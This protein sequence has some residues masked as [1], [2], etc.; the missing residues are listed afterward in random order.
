MTA[1]YEAR[2][3]GVHSAQPSARAK[4]LCP[5]LIF[6]PP[7]FAA[8]RAAAETIRAVFREYTGLVEPLSLD[9][10]FLDVTKPLKGPP[11][12]T[13][14]AKEIKARIL[15]QTGL[16]ASAGI[17]H[18]KFLAKVASAMNKPDGLTIVTPEEAEAF[19]AKLPIEKFF[20]VGPATTRRFKALGVM[21]GADLKEMPR[22]RLVRLFGKSGHW[23]YRIAR[24]E[25]RRPVSPDRERKTLSA[26]RTFRED[27][28]SIEEM[29]S[30]II[31]IVGE[32]TRRMKKGG[33]EGRTVTVKIKY[34]DFAI[35]TR[36]R[37]LPAAIS[38]MEDLECVAI[39][40]L[41]EAYP[42]RPVRLLGVGVGRLQ[43]IDREGWQLAL[44]LRPPYTKGR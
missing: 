20:G 4:K 28:L 9:E 15:D 25:D 2:R 35:S 42:V 40:L 10:A 6:V 11:S 33:F 34:H 31:E 19:V 16:T 23:Y 17:S 27:I 13:L 14:I 36:S 26:E 29:Q 44:Q 3:Y 30:R 1:S 21:T 7:N 24:G 22:D 41:K 43:Q 39:E 12:A 32:V 18:N 38:S 5:E 8:Y 37:T